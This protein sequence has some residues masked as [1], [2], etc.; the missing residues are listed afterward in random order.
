MLFQLA[1]D[2]AFSQENVVKGFQACGIYPV[3]RSKIHS[4]FHSR[5]FNLTSVNE[6]SNSIFFTLLEHMAVIAPAT[7]ESSQS[8]F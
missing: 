3:N 5:S 1:P 7:S 8:E 2:K 6:A 4:S